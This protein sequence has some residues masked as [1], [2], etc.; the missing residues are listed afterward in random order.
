LAQQLNLVSPLATLA[1]GYSILQNEQGQILR[2]AEDTAC[3]QTLTARLGEG[4][5]KLRVEECG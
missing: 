1:R 2:R 3:G 4:R 5:L